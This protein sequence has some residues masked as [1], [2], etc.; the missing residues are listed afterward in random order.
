MNTQEEI[1]II[2]MEECAEV[3]KACSKHIRFGEGLHK[4]EEEIGDLM[5]MFEILEENRMIDWSLVSLQSAKKRKK[6][7]EWSSLDV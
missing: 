1:L 6:L 3:T 4:V 5:C 2:T 7:K